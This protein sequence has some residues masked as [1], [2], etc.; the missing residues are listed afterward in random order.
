MD[1]RRFARGRIRTSQPSPAVLADHS[2]P[3]HDRVMTVAPERLL[4]A[5]RHAA[6]VQQAAE[7]IRAAATTVAAVALSYDGIAAAAD[8][9]VGIADSPAP[10]GDRAAWARARADDHRRLALQMWTRAAAPGS[11][12]H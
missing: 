5:Q 12:T 10:Y 9:V 1:G 4:L 11:A 8:A 6:A 2:S 7:A 3:A